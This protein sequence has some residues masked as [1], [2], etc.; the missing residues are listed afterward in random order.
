MGANSSL[1]NAL[2]TGGTDGIGKEV[3]RGLARA[4]HQLI[5]VGRDAEK[6]ARAAQDIS[7]T[8]GNPGVRFI[9]ADLSLVSEANRLAEEAG[10]HFPM[11]HYLVHSAGVVRGWHEL[12]PEG[13]ES[14][15]AINY[16][17][18]FALTLRLL[19]FL[20][21]AGKPGHTARIVILGGAAQKGKI[22]FEDMSLTRNFGTRRAV[23]QFCQ[24]NDVFTTELSRRLSSNYSERQVT[25]TCL[26]LGVV[27]TNIR[28]EFPRWMKWLVPLVLD[29]LLGQTPQEAAEPALRLLLSGEFEGVTGALFLKIRKFKRVAPG[30]AVLDPQTGRRLWELTEH[31]VS[32]ASSAPKRSISLANA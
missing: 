20:K 6:G 17:S 24:A 1:K 27:R 18:R 19:R 11:L 10:S 28:R 15:L 14:N 26:K 23:L 4:G 32:S 29:P 16:V 25:I 30:A 7:E 21:L 8:T 5:L 13:I 2:V 31:L 9:Q 12:T 3:A 22:Y